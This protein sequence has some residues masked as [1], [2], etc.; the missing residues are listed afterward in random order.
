MRRCLEFLCG[1]S[2]TPQRLVWPWNPLPLVTPMTS[3]NSPSF[4]S[5]SNVIS[6]PSCSRAKVRRAFGVVPGDADLEQARGVRRDARDA[7]GLGVDD[8]AYLLARGVGK[9]RFDVGA[10]RPDARGSDARDGRRSR[11]TT[12]RP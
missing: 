2:F 6:L 3:R 9:V 7:M 8:E 10:A 5:A 1:W 4:A 12:P 11:R